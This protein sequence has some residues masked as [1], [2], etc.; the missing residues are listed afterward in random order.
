M[1][2]VQKSTLRTQYRQ[3]NSNSRNCLNIAITK[4]DRQPGSE[5]I[6]RFNGLSPEMGREDT[7]GRFFIPGAMLS[8]WQKSRFH[9]KAVGNDTEFE[10]SGCS[11]NDEPLH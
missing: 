1:P 5:R 10:R 7:A 6:S 9:P 4:A 11:K 2:I 3:A 8:G